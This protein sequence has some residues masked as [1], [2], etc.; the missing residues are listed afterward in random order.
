MKINKFPRSTIVH[1]LVPAAG[2][3]ILLWLL[4][5]HFYR[6]TVILVDDRQITVRRHARTVG[7]L[8]QSQNITLKGMDLVTPELNAAVPLRGTVRVTRVTERVE[9]EDEYAPFKVRWKKRMNANLRPVELQKGIQK[10]HIK[11]IRIVFHDNHEVTRQVIREREIN[12]T[13]YRLVLI[14]KDDNIEQVYDLSRCKKVKM[15]ATA[16]YP[17]DPL[18][19]KDGTITCLG[20]KMQRGIVA[21]DPRTIPLRTRVFVDGYGY[22]YAG[23]TGSAIKGHRIDL[24]VNNATEEKSW[25]HRPVTLYILGKSNSW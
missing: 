10:R 24:G 23:D 5:V 7:E 12:K 4:F 14:G 9:K 16:Y 20:Q 21:V 18:C 6:Q 15:L 19:W 11:E 2:L 25:M 22:G 3:V 13:V 8:L 1:W 17:G